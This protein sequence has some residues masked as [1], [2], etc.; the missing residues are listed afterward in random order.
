MDMLMC[1]YPCVNATSM[2]GCQ[3][4]SVRICCLRGR[5]FLVLGIMPTLDVGFLSLSL[6]L[7]N[8]FVMFLW[9]SEGGID[10]FDALAGREL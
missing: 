1:V 9:S 6:S 10:T 8:T 7:F 4:I 2:Y 3:S 5:M